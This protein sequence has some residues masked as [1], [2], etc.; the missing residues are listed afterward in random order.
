MSLTALYYVNLNCRSLETSRA[1]YVALGF[2]VEAE[3]PEMSLAAVAEGLAIG[4]H[5]VKGVLLRLGEG[6]NT[7]LLDLLEWIE[8]PAPQGRSKAANDP[9]IVR[10]SLFSDDFSADYRRIEAMGV[11]FL[12]APMDHPDPRLP[13]PMFVCFRDPDG[14]IL[15]LV[16]RPSKVRAARKDTAAEQ[17]G[18]LQPLR[19]VPARRFG[20]PA[21]VSPRLQRAIAELITAPAYAAP[22]TPGNAEGWRAFA[23][24]I[25]AQAIAAAPTLREQFPHVIVE[26][27]IAGVAV[28]EIR[29]PDLSPGF[30]GRTLLHFHGGGYLMGRGLAGV[31]EAVI[32]ASRWRATVL[33]VDYRMPPEH[34][35]PCAIEDAVAVWRAL[36]EMQSAQSIGAFGSSAGGGLLL[37]LCAR[38]LALGLPTPGAIALNTPWADLT[39]QSD[40]YAINDG[41]DGVWPRYDD[42]SAAVARLYAGGEPLTNPLVSPVYGDFSGFPPAILTTGTR[43]LLL[44]DTV[45]VHRA[46]RA[47]GVEARL[48]VYEALSHGQ[49]VMAHDTPESEWIFSDIAAFF[50]EQL[51]SA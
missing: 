17:D 1:F 13:K 23:D 16:N 9:G 21:S 18:M 24:A 29:P 25:D 26:R 36:V 34:P 40:S 27:D 5:R 48:E 11:E 43:D 37:A 14:N 8:P 30:A 15:E 49:H 4:P 28:R 42:M 19:H 22:A 3:I 12:S 35:F 31:A 7:T 51:S 50:A 41:V 46:L 10:L 38:L 2:T 44:S 32:A 47:A 45:R 39:G 33:S 6:S 20:V